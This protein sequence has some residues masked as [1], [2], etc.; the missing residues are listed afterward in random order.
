[1][2]Q[3]K[4]WEGWVGIKAVAVDGMHGACQHTLKG[5]RWEHWPWQERPTGLAML[6]E[7]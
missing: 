5:E 7:N 1:M 6:H 3:M 2:V 4:T